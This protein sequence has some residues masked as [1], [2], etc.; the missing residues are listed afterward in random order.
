[1]ACITNSAYI[2]AAKDQADAITNQALA[3]TAIY[4]GLALWQRNTSG[5]IAAMQNEIAN[6]QIKLAE[7]LHDHA[8]KFWPAEIALV[9]DAFGETKY[10]PQYAATSTQWASLVDSTMQAAR[11][12]WLDTMRSWCM[13]ADK[14][15]DA[16][17]Q[18]NAQS[19]RADL[20]SYADRQEEARAQI[21]NDR[22]YARQYAVL[23][24]GR[25]RL[26]TV[27]S[28]QQ[29]AG[30]VGASAAGML[31]GTINSALEAFGYY[32]ARNEPVSWGRGIRETFE[33]RAPYEAPRAQPSQPAVQVNPVS[34]PP[35]AEARP[36]QPAPQQSRCGPMPGA[37]ASWQEW[38]DWNECM[39]YK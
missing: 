38:Q 36:I 4:V 21:I 30:T 13:A 23:G 19:T 6:R 5:S 16:R 25:D 9:N 12:D 26:S 22:R 31:T 1:M 3:D 29:I 27:P 18:R 15:E 20:I 11:S 7:Q 24:M 17:W 8:K 14:C 2:Q 28:F 35:I 33:A 10:N 37:E 32:P 34:L 39:G